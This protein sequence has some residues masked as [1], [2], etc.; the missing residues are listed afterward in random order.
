MG[1]LRHAII[2]LLGGEKKRLGYEFAAIS[3]AYSGEL[4]M[5]DSTIIRVHQHG[6]NSK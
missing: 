5:I 6:A 2:A 1:R 3:K 4:Q